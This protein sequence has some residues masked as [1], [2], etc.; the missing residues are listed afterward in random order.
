MEHK[1]SEKPEKQILS[2]GYVAGLLG[3]CNRTIYRAV[4]AGKIRAVRFGGS[5]GIPADEVKRICERGF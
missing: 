2:V 4:K 1:K 5:V 3:K